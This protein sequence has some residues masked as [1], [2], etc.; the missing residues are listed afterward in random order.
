MIKKMWIFGHI[1]SVIWS[2]FPDKMTLIVII[3]EGT[4]RVKI[5]KEKM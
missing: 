1:V 2:V 3:Q 5:P 4:R